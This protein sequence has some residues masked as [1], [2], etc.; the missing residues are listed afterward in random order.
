MTPFDPAAL[1]AVLTAFYPIVSV[2][3]LAQARSDRPWAFANGALVGDGSVLQLGDGRQFDLIG[4]GAWQ[5]VGHSA[6]PAV[7][8]VWD[9]PRI[10]AYFAGFGVAV[11]D[12][13]I[14][15]WLGY[16]TAWGWK[17]P[18]YFVY[19]LSHAQELVDAGKA[20]AL[21]AEP[22]GNV[23]ALEAGP[24]DPV[25]TAAN[26]YGFGQD[27]SFE[28]LVSDHLGA[29]DGSDAQLD[30]VHAT[31][32]QNDPAAAATALDDG[33]LDAA[34]GAHQAGQAATAGETIDDIAGATDG[35]RAG[36][37]DT[38]SG[39]DEPPPPD[40]APN[41]PG[42]PPPKYDGTGTPPAA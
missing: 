41:D 6:D 2:A 12:S 14:A 39:Y 15:Q 9:G 20:T 30:A 28:S 31:V 24:L 19:R 40:A 25:D 10:R 21:P 27:P 42:P 33:T 1:L 18:G 17:D 22:G 37:D 13:V 32:T 7:A 29:L 35:Q 26:Y 11:A 34:A 38:R 16:W 3:A 23:F 8:G 5:V 36:I 4:A